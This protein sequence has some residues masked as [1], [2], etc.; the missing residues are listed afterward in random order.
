MVF[1]SYG[2]KIFNDFSLLQ[3]GVGQRVF[4]VAKDVLPVAQGYLDV[5]KGFK[6]ADDDD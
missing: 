3:E 5:Y 2:S 1:F 4:K 6:N